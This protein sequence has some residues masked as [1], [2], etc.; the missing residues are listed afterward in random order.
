MNKIIA[1]IAA[2]KQRFHDAITPTGGTIVSDIR[3]IEATIEKAIDKEHRA[4]EKLH[5]TRLAIEAALGTKN[6]EIDAAFK[7][8]NTVGNLTK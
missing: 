2:L 5:N 3:K 4:L 8:L 1:L 6:G 7:L